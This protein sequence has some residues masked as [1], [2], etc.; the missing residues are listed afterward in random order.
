MASSRIYITNL[1]PTLGEADFKKHFA[2]QDAI[3]DAKLLAHR[4][5]GFIG[6]KTPEAAAKAV[7]YFNKSFIRMSRIGV[8][9]ADPVSYSPGSPR[10]ILLTRSSR[11]AKRQNPRKEKGPQLRQ[12]PT[13]LSTRPR[14]RPRT[15]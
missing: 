7:K 13:L 6:Y 12:S 10:K 2:Q 5:I 1:P 9:L 14:R 11:S 3:T 8:T 4:R 15:H